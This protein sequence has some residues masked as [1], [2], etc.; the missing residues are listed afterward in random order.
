MAEIQTIIGSLPV[1]RGEYDAATSYFR[2]N[3][4]TMYGSTFQSVADENVGSPPAEERADGKVY[5]INT[6]KWII[7]AN[8]LAAYNA[9]SRIEH[10]AENTE[11]KDEEG[12]V[13]KTPFSYIQSEEFIIAI[14]DAE[15]KLLAGIQWD[16]TPVHGKNSSLEDRMLVQL[17]QIATKL[18]SLPTSYINAEDFTTDEYPDFFVMQ[19]QTVQ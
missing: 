1:L 19:S 14:V 3:Q 6:D 2:D 18:A 13:V 12:E 7:V 10:L 5:A 16:G 4:V 9:G 15:D 11:V 8:A 17:E